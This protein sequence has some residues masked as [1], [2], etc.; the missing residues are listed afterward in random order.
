MAES[1]NGLVVA[2]TDEAS[3]DI[4]PTTALLWLNRAWRTMLGR[5][6]A[7]VDTV[8]FGTTSVS[9][10]TY[11]AP[12]GVIELYS[13]EVAGVPYGRA[14]RN[15][16][17]WN[18]Q[19]RLSWT[20][21][22]ETGLFY[23]D[24][25]ASSVRQITLLPTP[26]TAGLAITGLAATFPPDLTNDASGDTLLNAWVDG[27]YEALIA[28]AMSIGYSREGNLNAKAGTDAT[29]NAETEELRRDT[30]RRFR[31]AGPT[32]IRVEIPR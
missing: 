5:A 22:G 11:D 2:L 23:P 26:D 6:R 27:H 4:T 20:Y 15:D 21:Q 29:F 19:G 18:E 7:Y 12:S 10:A 30:K 3:F 32:Q 28:G 24:A 13:L 17:Y 16:V 25:T 8:S 14:R 1:V 31:G 9:D